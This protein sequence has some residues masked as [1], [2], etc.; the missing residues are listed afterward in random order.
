MARIVQTYLDG[1]VWS[2][3]K[4]AEKWRVKWDQFGW[5]GSDITEEY[6]FDADAKW[7][8]DYAFPSLKV[9]VEIDG[10]G[11][12]HQAVNR[13][14]DNNEKANAAVEQ[15]WRILRYTSKQLGSH[16]SCEEA[17]DQVCRVLAGTA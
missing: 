16:A 14:T 5:K 3:L 2:K 13:L 6:R 8:F 15:G 4:P 9:A 12:G 1:R 7:R 11:F 10:F 17:V